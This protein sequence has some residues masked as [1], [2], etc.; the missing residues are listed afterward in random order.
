MVDV[1]IVGAGFSGIGMAVRL[2]QAGISDIVVL[3]RADEVGGTWRDNTFPGAAC[4]IPSDLYSF[5]FA[6]NPEWTRVFPPQGE[7]L[8]Y[9]RDVAERFGVTPKIRFG[10]ELER[11][12]WDE[13]GRMWRLTTSTGDVSARVL[14]SAS[15]P[16]VDPTW[17]E[18]PGL[19]S[20]AGAQF[21]SA[22][23]DH[24]V[25]L[26]GRRVAVIGTGASA[27]QLV[28]EV[29]KAAAHVDVFQ[30]S[31][32]WILPRLDRGTS[33]L[34]RA[35][36]RRFP[37]LQL[38]SRGFTFRTYELRWPVFAVPLVGRVA[39]AGLGLLRRLALRDRDLATRATPHY[40]VG[41]KRILISDDWYPALR[42]PNV[43]LIGD[44]IERIEPGGVVTSDGT[45]HPADVLICATGF[46]VTAPVIAHR[47]H[48]R[49]GLSLAG[50][51]AP[52]ASALR[53]TAVAGFPNFFQLLGPNTTL[54]HNSM[55]GMIESQ[56]GYVRQ[57]V[58]SGRV[59]EVR[60][61]AQ[62]A[63]A[64]AIQ[65]AMGGIVWTTGGCSSYYVDAEGRNTAAWPHGAARFA[66]EL[67]RFDETEYVATVG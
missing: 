56:V 9:L 46:A 40:R 52:H 8:A 51:W 41:C 14:V 13:K 54:A 12:D 3:E 7:I 30:R 42:A 18:I 28:P 25:D 55:I 19:S 50:A 5:S 22:R 66:R 10:T 47:I 23:W 37:G 1:A 45:L 63:Y 67:R 11:A 21:H 29:R 4:D 16:F 31:A 65:D 26:S 58:Q 24:S 62:A 17:P 48:G 38:I 57:A 39:G 27:I 35:A 34:R 20:F 15:G 44:A 33:R 64:A 60:P 49:D 53:G 36:F 32:P 6:P 61:E 59:L 43:A 2:L